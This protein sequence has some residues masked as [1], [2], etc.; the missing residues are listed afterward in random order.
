MQPNCCNKAA[1][2]GIIKAGLIKQITVRI[3]DIQCDYTLFGKVEYLLKN[4]NYVIQ[5]VDYSNLVNIF[6]QV[7]VDE[8]PQFS[9]WL[10]EKTNAEVLIDELELEIVAVD[11][12]PD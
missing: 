9:D 6:V 11:Y 12:L 4:G 7:L 3:V 5:K 2:A 10:T 8:V 1:K